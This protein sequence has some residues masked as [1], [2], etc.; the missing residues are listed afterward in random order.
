MMFTDQEKDWLAESIKAL[1][2]TRRTIEHAMN[3]AMTDQ[4]IHDAVALMY[5][6]RG[7]LAIVAG[8]IQRRI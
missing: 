7:D 3:H 1:D 4:E 5:K 6:L 2:E 8:I